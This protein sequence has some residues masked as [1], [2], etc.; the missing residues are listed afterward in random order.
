[1]AG[2]ATKG[3]NLKVALA[4]RLRKER[5]LQKGADLKVALRL[6]KD[7]SLQKVTRQEAMETERQQ[8]HHR[9]TKVKG[10][11][12]AAVDHDM[13]RRKAKPWTLPREPMQELM[14]QM[15]SDSVAGA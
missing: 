9:T 3:A 14:I 12:R 8:R 5:S 10:L 2:I 4:L 7:R 13:K 6:R 1:M 15:R 11:R